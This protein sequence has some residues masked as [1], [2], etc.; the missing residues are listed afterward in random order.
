M[1]RALAPKGVA[2]RRRRS[3]EAMLADERGRAL[4]E[5]GMA[6]PHGTLF[7]DWFIKA[8]EALP[9]IDWVM[10]GLVTG[11]KLN[12]VE[13]LTGL[14]PDGPLDD[15]SYDLAGTPC[16]RTLEQHDTFT[17]PRDVARRYPQDTML[18]DMGLASYVG[19]PL[20]DERGEAL[21][22]ISCMG[23]G[24]LGDPHPIHQMLDV[25]GTRAASEVA[26][27]RSLRDLRL[28]VA[29]STP[30][31]G[32][33]V[34]HQLLEVLSSALNV[35]LVFVSEFIDDT[36]RR[37]RALCDLRDGV[38]QGV[39]EYM[40]PGTPTE[41]V[42]DEGFLFVSRGVCQRFP[43]DSEL[44][45]LNAEGYM[46]RAMYDSAGT[47]LGHVGVIDDRPLPKRL[48]HH[49]LFDILA[50]R[51]ASEIE[52]RRSEEQRLQMERDLQ[53]AQK[54]E[55]LGL[56]AGSVAH[57]FNNLLVG[58][59]G[60]VSMASLEEQRKPTADDDLR[61]H[62]GAIEGAAHSAAELARQMLAYSGRGR[63]VTE[64][65]GVAPLV[66]DMLK[67]LRASVPHTVTLDIAHAADL[68]PV[69]ADP[70]Q[71]RQVIMNLVINGAEACGDSTGS[72]RVELAAAEVDQ[73]RVDRALLAERCKPGS[74]VSV[75]VADTGCGLAPDQLQ[76]IFDPFY[77]TKF[78]GRGLGLAAVQGILRGHGA[79]L[80]LESEVGGG[81]TFR[82][83]WPALADAVQESPEGEAPADPSRFE[84]SGT[85][86]IID[87][88]PTVRE[89]AADLLG[90]VGFEII[91]AADGEQGVAL[92]AEHD[93]RAVLL[94]MTMP[95][96]SG[97]D[98]LEALRKHDRDVPVVVMSGYSEDEVD[99]RFHG[100]RVDGFL[101]KPFDFETLLLVLRRALDARER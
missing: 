93:V 42:Y 48:P 90:A 75:E 17:E 11:Q 28:A 57:D 45:Y 71:L 1:E 64:R 61:R 73:R 44:R 39:R 13:V 19:L 81:T 23:R 92:H 34:F 43:D 85:V 67:L 88:E 33:D 16:L 10:V 70:A 4:L 25:F 59:L 50:Q 87:D 3:L 30:R 24:P 38:L 66:S 46:G 36:P 5:Q 31:A 21:G 29:A 97:L 89:A 77:T 86:L 37:A 74:F 101:Q 49:H 78:T 68:P 8:L 52:R 12:T 60:H 35:K 95:T 53:Q 56:L 69:S 76:R 94:D 26:R 55:S 96:L 14:G 40:L 65:V 7:L 99:E 79:L 47:L 15:L 54:L 62:L 27:Q 6:R 22:L 100:H 83:L 2:A 98:T 80:E 58:I 32:K 91:T 41:V 84:G 20:Y 9:G 63:F 18:A 51:L 82:V 72:V